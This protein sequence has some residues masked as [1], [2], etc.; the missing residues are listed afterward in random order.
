MSMRVND[1]PGRYLALL[2]V[3]PLLV[4]AGVFVIEC[5][6]VVAVGLFVFACALFFYELFWICNSVGFEV[7][8]VPFTKPDRETAPVP[9]LSA[10]RFASVPNNSFS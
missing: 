9:D 1:R 8:T 10:M 3:S 4:V 7:A 2:V 5:Q 6:P